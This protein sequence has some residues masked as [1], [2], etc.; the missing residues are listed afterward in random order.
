[1]PL[2]RL[3]SE[4]RANTTLP[5]IQFDQS[6]AALGSGGFAI[7]WSAEAGDGNGY[8]IAVQRFDANGNRV[9]GQTQVNTT[10]TRNQLEPSI[11]A[12]PSGGF[13]VTWADESNAA[14]SDV[15]GRIFDSGGNALGPD[16]LVNTVT[17]NHQSYPNVFGLPGGGFV[18]SWADAGD[19]SNLATAYNVRAQIFDSSGA[20]VGGEFAVHSS[21]AGVQTRPTGIALGAGNFLILWSHI[22]GGEYDVRGQIFDSVGNRIGAEFQIPA[23]AAGGESGPDV[24]ALPNGGFVVSW[25]TVEPYGTPSFARAQMFD[26]TGARVGPEVTASNAGNKVGTVNVTGLASGGFLVSWEDNQSATPSTRAQMFDS[27]GNPLGTQFQLNLADKTGGVSDLATLGSGRIVATWSY[28]SSYDVNGQVFRAPLVGT[29][30]GDTLDGGGEDDAIAGLA[31]DDILSGGGGNDTLD[32]GAGAD[33]MTGGSGNDVYA[34]DNGGDEVVE[35]AD[36]GIDE[37][38]SGLAD[39]TLPDNVENLAGTSVAGGG[40]ILRGNAAGNLLTGGAG[41]DII[42]LGSAGSDT[43][44]GGAGD[45]LLVIDWRDS[46]TAFVGSGYDEYNVG[47]RLGYMGY[48]RD[49][50][51]RS[52]NFSGIERFEILAGS[53]GDHLLGAGGDDRL[54]GG[55]G[56][57]WL[58]GAG[59]ADILDG[60]AGIDTADY[61]GGGVYLTD[62]IVN[63]GGGTIANPDGDPVGPRQGLDRHGGLDS[64]TGIENVRTGYGDDFVHGDS[65]AN[66][67]ETDFGTDTLIGAA[68]DDVLDGGYGADV[69]RGGTGDDL[70]FVDDAGDSV[71]ENAGEGIDEVRT[72]LAVYSLAALPFVEDLSASADL[73]A[74]DF[75]GNSADNEV[76]GGGGNDVLRLYDGGDDT[77]NGGAGNDSIFFIGALTGADVVNGGDGGDTLV[78]QGAYGA[79]TL[80]ANVTRIENLSI[81]AGSNTAFGDP[82]TN[83]YDYVL[84]TNDANFAAGVQARINAA[85]LLEGE[86]FTFDGSAEMDA[87]FVVYGGKGRDTLTGGLGNDIFFFAEERFASGDTVNGGSGYDGMFLRGNYTI[88]FNAPGFTGLFTNIDNLTLTSATDERYARGGG[89]EFDYALTLSDAIVGAGGQ[90]TVSGAL[91]MATETMI[92]DASA[93]TNGILRLFGGKASDTLKGGAMNDLLHGNLGA[94]TLAGGGGA[95]A[96]RF[97]N[98][99]ESNSASMDQIL[100][101]TP[102]TDKIELDRIDADTLTAGNQAFSWIGSDAFTGTA[103][104]LRA[105]EQGG[106]WF[107]EG[108]TNGDGT[109]DLV[110][111]LTLQGPTPLSASDFLL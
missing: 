105:Y 74:R 67:I 63:L 60:G 40:Q 62:V 84:T 38:E 80:T 18:V 46:T 108:D 22:E 54:A 51:G 64:L 3:G 76:T 106:T 47:Q 26:S 78:L 16:F 88:D 85:A 53:A 61:S 103:G 35:Q 70:Y 77:A 31:S 21:L 90:L 100:D 17:A 68:G 72:A 41:D 9:G 92:V 57:D 10:V 15:R 93:E 65:A 102:G 12:L 73:L 50:A 32:G 75:R 30:L 48:H 33:R 101:F 98:V 81:L 39:Y 24:A 86:D 14:S 97:Q 71:E 28:G 69:M 96:F 2:K 29:P 99:T 91:L 7:A 11:A 37:I 20:R 44:R 23:N 83:R 87:S 95:D 19:T 55:G 45:D 27:A 82:G 89:T 109:A 52:V 6:V 49:G 79:L 34:V 42:H 104:Q 110:I 94:D 66:R 8:G 43:A 59:G 58:D 5:G 111:A 107:V 4:F 25:Q 36:Q 1:M 13:V 56:D